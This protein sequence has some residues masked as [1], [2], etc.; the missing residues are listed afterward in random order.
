MVKVTHAST[1]QVDRSGDCSIHICTEV[2]NICGSPPPPCPPKCEPTRMECMPIPTRNAIKLRNGEL[3]R[4]FTFQATQTSPEWYAHLLRMSLKLK[5][6]GG[7]ACCREFCYAP[8][9]VTVDGRVYYAWT[10]EFMEAPAGYYLAT[11]AVQGMTHRQTVIF[12]PYSYVSALITWGTFDS[13]GTER[14]MIAPY[15]K[16]CGCEP[17]SC[18]D[19]LPQA[20]QEEFIPIDDCGV[21]NVGCE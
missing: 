20:I 9:G 16:G 14:G 12:K 1:G 19:H 3:G 13:C 8:S 7:D 4:Y 11:F 2:P 6:M 10:R 21:C 17:M 18:C 5:R 15:L